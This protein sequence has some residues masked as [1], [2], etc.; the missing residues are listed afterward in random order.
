MRQLDVYCNWC[1]KYFKTINTLRTT[2][3]YF[4]LIGHKG[5]KCRACQKKEVYEMWDKLG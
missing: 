5:D 4:E 1:M 3:D 2:Y